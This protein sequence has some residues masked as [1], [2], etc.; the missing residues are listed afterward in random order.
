[1]Q[2]T[3]SSL[4]APITDFFAPVLR[5]EVQAER[6]EGEFAGQ[7]SW[8]SM[9]PDLFNRIIYVP[10]FSATSRLLSLFRWMQHGRVQLYILNIVITLLLLI[11]A[12]AGGLL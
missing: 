10:I 3:A 6:P 1:M 2:Y 7:I 12:M 9:T 11:A 5:S 4:A 8:V